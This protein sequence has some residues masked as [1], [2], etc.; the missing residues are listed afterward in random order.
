MT[1]QP[2]TLPPAIVFDWDNT[3]IDTLPLIADA[4]N[5]IRSHFGLPDWTMEE[6]HS[7][8]QQVGREGLRRHY[9]ERWQEAEKIFYDYIGANHLTGLRLMPGAEDLILWLKGAGVPMAILSN[10]RGGLLRAEVEQ[11]G[12]SGHF[13]VI[14]GPDDIDNIGKPRPEGMWAIMDRLA[15]QQD[16]RAHVWYAGD[17][18]NDLKTAHAA[19]V[20]PVFIENTKVS[21]VEN[22]VELQPVFHFR[23]CIDCLDYLKR[24]SDSAPK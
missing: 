18:G 14:L 13:S 2:H 12:W 16:M 3:L 7:S 22:I 9:G 8:T 5:R 6:V 23:G 24:L 21:H 20:I 4:N 19:G 17:T 11:L 15:T 10:K 1:L